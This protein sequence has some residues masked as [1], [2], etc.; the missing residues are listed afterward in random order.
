VVKRAHPLFYQ[1]RHETSYPS[2]NPLR[3]LFYCGSPLFKDKIFI[4]FLGDP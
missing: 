2:T 1:A 4:A 3:I